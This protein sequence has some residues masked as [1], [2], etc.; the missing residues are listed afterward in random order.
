[1]DPRAPVWAS[2]E[3][4]RHN[5]DGHKSGGQN[6]CSYVR[7]PAPSHTQTLSNPCNKVRDK[8]FVKEDFLRLLSLRRYVSSIYIYVYFLHEYVYENATLL[9]KVYWLHICSMVSRS[10][11]RRKYDVF[12]EFSHFLGIF[13]LS[14]MFTSYYIF[15]SIEL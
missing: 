12:L 2:E 1:M 8:Y 11:N 9:M 7:S 15:A 5:V 13:I 6:I 10:H 14:F 4:E 3:R